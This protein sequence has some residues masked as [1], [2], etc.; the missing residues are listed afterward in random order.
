MRTTLDIDD[1]VLEAIKEIAR[2]EKKAVVAVLSHFAREGILGLRERP[3][4][5]T[6]MGEETQASMVAPLPTFPP[7]PDYPARP[8]RIITLAHIQRIQDEIDREDM[9]RALNPRR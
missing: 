7:F 8:R 4:S 2:A 9:E 1:D 3:A 6:V 5:A